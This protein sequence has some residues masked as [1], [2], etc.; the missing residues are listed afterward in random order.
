[1]ELPPRWARNSKKLLYRAI[2]RWLVPTESA[3]A[4]VLRLQM[5]LARKARISIDSGNR[6]EI[7]AIEARAANER[8]VDLIDG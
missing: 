7:G 4:K 5:A 2:C 1:M 6:H 8:P 3:Q